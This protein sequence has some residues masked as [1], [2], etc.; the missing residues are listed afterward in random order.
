M[1]YDDS[2]YR[3]HEAKGESP[4][5]SWADDRY[6]EE[7]TFRGD[8]GARGGYDSETQG[9]YSDIR[10]RYSDAGIG[11][12]DVG[13]GYAESGAGYADES[14]GYS[15]GRFMD[16]R[17][18]QDDPAYQDARTDPPRR[19]PAAVLDDVFDDPAHG[20]PGR[21]RMVVHLIWEVLLLAAVV[22]VAFLLEREN[23]NAVRGG[24]LDLLLV[25]AAALGLLAIGAGLTLRAAAPNLALGPV[26]I[27]CALHFAEN[28]DNGVVAAMVPATAAVVG[29]GLLLALLVVG[30]HVPSWA[31]SLAV[32]L[33]AVVYIQLRTAPVEVQGGYDPTQHSLYLFGGFAALTVLGGLLGTI[34][35][36]RRSV[37]RFRPVADP[38]WRRGALASVI[39]SLCLIASMVLAAAAGVLLAAGGSGPVVPTT[40]FEWSGL[41]LGAAMLGGT[42][43]FGR[44]GGVTGT[45]FAVVLI[46]LFLRYEDERNL[47][48]ALAAVAA[49]T[50][51]AGLL[52]TRLVETFGRPRSAVE[53]ED[54]WEPE[55]DPSD[56]TNG[57][58]GRIGNWSTSLPAQPVETRDD[59]W[60]RWGSGR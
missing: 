36:V 8:S 18:Y 15:S 52:V 16:D 40:G 24:Q 19:V 20:E 28:G 13:A 31:A 50:V 10:S 37:G 43:A 1:A 23:P 44:R 17:P 38:A 49:A 57:R 33:A 3:R 26:A 32:G 55:P 35:T 22:G 12:S 56:W 42:S 54:D 9:G 14:T 7:T 48:I 39:T 21:D 45:L 6:D 29:L 34:K 59:P 4:G 58:T 46:I 30:L 11:R 47:D 53:S 51:A 2:I 5:R 27:A 25:A 60:D 41:A